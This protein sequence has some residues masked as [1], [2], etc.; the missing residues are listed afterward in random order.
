MKAHMLN[1]HPFLR[2]FV[3]GA[4]LA[5]AS[6]ALAQ[7]VPVAITTPGTVQS[8]IGTLDFKDGMPSAATA[9]KVYEHIDFT[10]AYEAFVNTMQ[11]AN[12]EA[13]RRGFLAAG[14]QDNQILVFSKLMDAKSLFLTANADT[15][16]FVGTLD[17]SKGP[18]VLETPPKA[19]G[20][21]DDAWWRWVIDF[22][23]PGPDRAEGGRYLILPPGYDGPVPEGGFYVARART[24]KVLI[25]GRMFL[26][27]NDP[28]PAVELIRKHTKIYPYNAGG[29]GTSIA[30]FLDGK[31]R[32]SRIEPPPAMVF[33]EGSGKV[34]NTVPPNDSS[35]FE[36]LND[37]VQR[38]PATALDPELMGPLAAIGIVKGKPFAPDARMKKILGE[39]VAVG[40]AASRT[41]L[42]APRDPSW[43]YY[44]DSAWTNFLFQS[45]YEF[46]TP[47]P[48][49]TREGVKPF[50]TTGYRQLD[51]RSA[52]FYGITGIT[53]AMAMRLPGVGSQYLLAMQDANK[54]FFDGGKTY[55]LTLP[56]GIPYANFWSLT[57][58]DNQTRSML[59][60]PQAYPRAGSQS[61]PSPAAEAGA[62]GS[63]TVVFSPQQPAG[64]PRGNWIQTVP[65]KGW[66][67]ILRLYGP[68]EPFFTKAWRPGEVEPVR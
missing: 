60:T 44:P 24:N 26:E 53:P 30:Q 40:N 51:A 36:L 48:M 27:N 22:G 6:L 67:V 28:Q 12:F 58:Y 33:H 4:L 65:G 64:V 45:G 61:Y 3:A 47:I 41:L 34:M 17:L 31:A 15:V 42:M 63:T 13:I 16:Y 29:E 35:Y 49:V 5:S 19:L 57:L 38:E 10:H 37:L 20:T 66:F 21:L 39:A 46:E 8:R 52:F 43:Y 14:V 1:P 54:Q 18:M 9:A 59:D 11:G 25:L 23:V 50:P 62:D 7:T 2:T 32:L 68:L 56:K 55:K